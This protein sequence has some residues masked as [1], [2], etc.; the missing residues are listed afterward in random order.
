[1]LCPTHWRF[2]SRAVR[3]CLCTS[4]ASTLEVGVVKG[5]V[6]VSEVWDEDFVGVDGIFSKILCTDSAK[7]KKKQTP[8]SSAIKIML[9]Y[10]YI[11]QSYVN[12]VARQSRGKQHNSTQEGKE[13][14]PGWDFEPTALCSIYRQSALPPLSYQQS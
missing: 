14:C 1:M 6:T 11:H 7:K 4:L 12:K 9:L 2:S 3:S 5:V 10:K 13:S 8:N